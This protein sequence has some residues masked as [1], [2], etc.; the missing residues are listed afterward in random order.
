LTGF[1][2]KEAD[3]QSDQPKRRIGRF[4]KSTIFGRRWVIGAV[5]QINGRSYIQSWLACR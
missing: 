1:T 2:R 3:E 5:I 4:L